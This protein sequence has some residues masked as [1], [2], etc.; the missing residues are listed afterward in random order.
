[1]GVGGKDGT[2]NVVLLENQSCST[3]YFLTHSQAELATG[4]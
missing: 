1:M 3:K 4:K 2:L